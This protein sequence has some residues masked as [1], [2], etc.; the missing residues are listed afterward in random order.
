MGLILLAAGCA[1]A[2]PQNLKDARSAYH[3]A[4]DGP[5]KDLAPAQLHAAN[6][7]LSLAEKTFDDEG[8]SENARDRAYVAMRKA[9]LAEVQ[10][11]I[12]KDTQL[13]QQAKQRSEQTALHQRDELK[14]ELQQTREQLNAETQRRQEAEA[15]QQ[16]A[17][18]QLGDVK[19][20]ARGTVITI[21]GSVS[22]ASGKATLLPSA[23]NRLQQ[24]ATALKQGDNQSKIIVEGH[25]DATGSPEKNQQL[26]MQRA[27]AVRK[28]LISDGVP[29]DR[30]QAVGYGETRPVADNASPAGR[31]TNRRV[32]IVVQSANNNQEPR[33]TNP[34]PTSSKAE[35]PNMNPQPTGTSPQPS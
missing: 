12:A 35:P 26:S 21:P 6:V 19:D 29:A 34:H 16:K 33:N 27:E 23:S 1:S 8:N 24:V 7:S 22:F 18:A 28:S 20:E 4:A 15:A 3:R 31:A 30:V 5:A 11:E 9:E 14:Q 25:T 32:E 17:L 2:P 13:A 10:A